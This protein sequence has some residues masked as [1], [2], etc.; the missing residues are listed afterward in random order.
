MLRE[1]YERT[2]KPLLKRVRSIP[3]LNAPLTSLLRWSLDRVG[4]ELPHQLHFLHRAGD[5]DLDLP[6]GGRVRIHSSG[7]DTVTSGLFW[8][9]WRSH[10]PETLGLFQALARRAVTVVDV[11]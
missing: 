8:W 11:G 2:L 3:A 6:L 5:F 7:D 1:G 10:E 9:G 4:R